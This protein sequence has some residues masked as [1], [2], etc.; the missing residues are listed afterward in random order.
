MIGK[1]LNNRYLIE[2]KIGCGGMAT[3]YKAK[4]Q[5]LE[6]DVAVKV[7]NQADLQDEDSIRKF[8]REA[9][10]AGSLS[11]YNIVGVYDVGEQDNIHYMVMELVEGQT[12]KE[13]IKERGS[14]GISETISIAMQICDALNHAHMNGVIHRDIKPQN[15]I[16]TQ[17]R[18][19]KVA[20]FGIARA[21]SSDTLTHSKDIFG[22]VR[23]FSPEQASGE[24]AGVK[25][26]M[27]SLGIVMYEMLSGKLPFNGDTPIAWAMKHINDDPVELVNVDHN[28]PKV[29]SD[30]V[31]KTMQKDPNYRFEDIS[32]LKEALI[33][34]KEGL[35]VKIEMVK[36][37]QPT[38]SKKKA[39]QVKK[40]PKK[41]SGKKSNTKAIV[42]S[43]IL[44]ALVAGTYFGY[45]WIKDFLEVPEV[46]VPNVVGDHLQIAK[47]KILEQGLEIDIS[48]TRKDPEIAANH[49]IIQSPVSGTKVKKGRVIELIISDG[50][51]FDEVPS[52]EGMTKNDADVALSNAGYEVGD[53]YEDYSDTVE[54]G[55]VI[56]QGVKAGTEL[57][58]GT[59]IDL[60]VSKGVKATKGPMPKLVGMTNQ[61]AM[62][63]II[64]NQFT[65]GEISEENSD[66]PA[67]I[68][69]SQD[70]P[71]GT[72]LEFGTVINFTISNG[73]KP[74][75]TP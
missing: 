56:K 74:V 62:E 54:V 60:V 9:R 69:L 72:E 31:N 2:E 42:I 59:K 46:A 17:D 22:S 71:E 51:Q 7:L 25:S 38:V 43:V 35:P 29:L 4:D 3:V 12:L 5:L 24:V 57:I 61:S 27:Y 15:I 33:K 48:A 50:P 19:I 75:S 44:L 64:N 58:L 41:K 67:G 10:A 34:F 52:V 73:R 28:V 16:I 1:L 36:K 70:Y 32:E 18:N 6:R 53:V 45:V 39:K 55:I 40:T 8:R 13:Y 30:I 63:A 47:A 11:H 20:D 14:L 68:V 66:K 23:Y 26:D 37:K 49:V 65:I 21:V